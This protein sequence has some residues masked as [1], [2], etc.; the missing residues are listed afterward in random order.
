MIWLSWR[1]LRPQVVIAGGTLAALAAYLVIL[2]LVMRNS[3]DRDV[4]G[5]SGDACQQLRAL[6]QDQYSP[7]VARVSRTRCGS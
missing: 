3:Y 6:F 4:V 5:C 1:Q 7:Y 2:G